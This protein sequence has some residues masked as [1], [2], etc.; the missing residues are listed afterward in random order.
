MKY[1][2]MTLCVVFGTS[3]FADEN[4]TSKKSSKK[5]INITSE[6]G[7]FG[8]GMN[9]GFSLHVEKNSKDFPVNWAIG[10][11]AADGYSVSRTETLNNTSLSA[12]GQT[13]WYGIA[14][15]A[16][17]YFAKQRH[18]TYLE[19]VLSLRT[20]SLE[21]D[22]N[23]QNITSLARPYSVDKGASYQALSPGVG[24]GY[25]YLSNSGFILGAR[26]GVENHLAISDLPGDQNDYFRDQIL[27]DLADNTNGFDVRV[28][29]SIGFG[30]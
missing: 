18:S 7:Y 8:V 25:R 14:P 1:L 29:L 23:Y 12:R 6:F 30:F 19:G 26:A 11:E 28:D 2:V 20:V 5:K 4:V 24:V 15:K 27:T 3:A 9:Q 13:K 16:R 10:L 17:F 22:V 21:L